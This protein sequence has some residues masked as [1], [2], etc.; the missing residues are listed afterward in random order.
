MRV[1]VE[2]TFVKTQKGAR[3][4]QKEEKENTK[5]NL[6]YWKNNEN[7]FFIVLKKSGFWEHGKHKNKNTSPSSNKFFVFFVFSNKNPFLKQEPNKP[8]VRRLDNI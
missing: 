5:N 2:L 3:K 6:F 4:T 8:L 1:R 7:I